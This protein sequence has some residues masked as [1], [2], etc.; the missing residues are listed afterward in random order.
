MNLL[1][2]ALSFA[3][4]QSVTCG[5]KL[6]QAVN[7]D[8]VTQVKKLAQD[9]KQLDYKDSSGHN[10]LY[11]A[12][13]LN[14]FEIVKALLEAGAST[15]EKYNAN[16]ESILFEATRL[17]STE[18]VEALLKANPQLLK[19][20]NADQETVMFEAVRAE[21]SSLVKLYAKKGLSLKDKNKSGKTPKDL[22]TATNPEMAKALKQLS[23]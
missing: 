2:L 13:S 8:S 5:S 23:K 7:E 6:I 12:V 20:K 4:A 16:K 19:E 11:H 3:L 1:G 21:Q 9:K 10:A 15:K 14:N 18:C 17:G 22:A